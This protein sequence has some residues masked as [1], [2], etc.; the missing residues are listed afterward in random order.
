MLQCYNS[1]YPH[2]GRVGGV[3]VGLEVINLLIFW[4]KYLKKK[5]ICI[6]KM[7]NGVKNKCPLALQTKYNRFNRSK[8][9]DWTKYGPNFQVVW[10]G[11]GGG[12]G[13]GA[14]S[15]EIQLVRRDINL[16]RAIGQ[17]LI[18]NTVSICSQDIEQKPNSEVNQGP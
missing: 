1:N 14:T 10:G 2:F 16:C 15:C 11:G 13:G 7:L 8:L 12:G 9:I 18:S 17:L 3:S 5:I 4:L 6:A